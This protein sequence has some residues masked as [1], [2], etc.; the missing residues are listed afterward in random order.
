MKSAIIRTA[1]CVL[2]AVVCPLQAA[3]PSGNADKRG[4]YTVNTSVSGEYNYHVFVPQSYTPEKGAGIHLFFHGQGKG[5]GIESLKQWEKDFCEPYRLI[6]INMQYLDGDNQTDTV[7]KLKAAMQAV[8]QVM[9]D[10]HVIPG[11]GVIA[12]FSGGGLP[13]ALFYV[14]HAND[15]PGPT[16]PFS[17]SALYGSN[18]WTKFDFRNN[19]NYCKDSS[20]TPSRDLCWIVTLGEKEWPM[21]GPPLGK[22]QIM[23]ANDLFAGVGRAGFDLV[24]RVEKDKGHNIAAGDRRAAA[25]LFHRHDL[26]YDPFVYEPQFTDPEVRTQAQHANQLQLGPVLAALTRTLAKDKLKDETRK[27]AE[28]LKSLVE[29]RAADVLAMGTDLADKDP[30]LFINYQKQLDAQL[31]ATPQEAAWKQASQ[32]FSKKWSKPK[33]GAAAQM[34]TQMFPQLFIPA[35]PGVPVQSVNSLQ[36]MIPVFGPDS[37]YGKMIAEWLE[38]APRS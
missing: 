32:A 18:F 17:C 28:L 37:S 6:A 2:L 25:A 8:E 30:L 27:Q 5:P 33:V 21:G 38:L 4:S 20:I 3:S 10:Y 7:G 11:R 9:A 34:L 29:E 35:T 22:T 1:L 12:S 24:F 26:A 36:S 15:R 14:Q 16:W 19:R 23:D 31:K 13:H